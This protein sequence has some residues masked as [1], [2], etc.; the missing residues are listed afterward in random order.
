MIELPELD[1]V[2]TRLTHARSAAGLTQAALAKLAGVEKDI[3]S[4]I[5]QGRSVGPEYLLQIA[6]ACGV[7]ITWLR[8]HKG[9][10][11]DLIAND[12]AS[13]AHHVVT[14]SHEHLIIEAQLGVAYAALGEAI[15]RLENLEFDVSVL[16]QC[17]KWVEEAIY[18][19]MYVTHQEYVIDLTESLLTR[20]LKQPSSET[21]VSDKPEQN[22]TRKRHPRLPEPT[23]EELEAMTPA[24]ELAF[25]AMAPEPNPV[26]P[27][28]KR[29]PATKKSTNEQLIETYNR[30]G[31]EWSSSFRKA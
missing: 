2:A 7:S 11:K 30:L 10:M 22:K 6:K 31:Q 12:I 24:V 14:G 25:E 21:P 19:Q 4:H 18:N 3:V 28:V 13:A 26:K 17:R 8:S 16:S 23:A 27:K 9:K 15:Q 1:T 5:E 20:A 29:R